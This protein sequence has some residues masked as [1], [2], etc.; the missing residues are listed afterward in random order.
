METT[1]PT[2]S[3]IYIS[4]DFLF[5]KFDPSIHPD[6]VLVDKKYARKDIYLHKLCHQAF[7]SM[8]EAATIDSINL[9]IISGTR[10]FN[11]QKDLWERKWTGRTLVNGKKLNIQYRK[12]IPR[13]LKILEYTAPPGFS[14]HHWGTDVDINSVEEDYFKTEQGLKIYNWLNT[15]AIRFGFEQT[16]KELG[17]ERKSGFNEEKWHWSFTPISNQIWMEMIRVFKQKHIADFNGYR[18]VQKLDLL[19]NYIKSINKK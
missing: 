2:D 1:E 6:F 18:S 19:Q 17:E 15:N 13:A 9:F 3:V 11:Q 8:A 4:L 16:Y 7:V 10:T 14:R 5:G 12:S